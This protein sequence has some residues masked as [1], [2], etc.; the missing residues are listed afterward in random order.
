MNIKKKKKNDMKNKNLKNHMK[1]LKT[2]GKKNMKNIYLNY[3]N[4]KKSYEMFKKRC[5]KKHEK[6][7]LNKKITWNNVLKIIENG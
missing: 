5:K 4:K 2:Y 3:L 1:C 7:N 6:F